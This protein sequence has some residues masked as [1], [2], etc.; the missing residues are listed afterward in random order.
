MVSTWV[1]QVSGNSTAWNALLNVRPGFGVNQLVLHVE[2]IRWSA[3]WKH[4]LVKLRTLVVCDAAVARLQSWYELIFVR[5]IEVKLAGIDLL[6][7][8]LDGSQCAR[9]FHLNI[10]TVEIVLRTHLF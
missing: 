6:R 8:T 9:L 1:H 3:I 4:N 5:R 7:D 10:D 2:R